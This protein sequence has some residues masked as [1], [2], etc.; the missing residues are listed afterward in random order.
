MGLATIVQIYGQTV[1]MMKHKTLFDVVNR[2][3]EILPLSSECIVVVFTSRN[4]EIGLETLFLLLQLEF[5]CCSAMQSS[6]LLDVVLALVPVDA[7]ILL[8]LWVKS[9]QISNRI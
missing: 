1:F 5:A 8:F 3:I 2:L 6:L 9:M 7:L 4:L